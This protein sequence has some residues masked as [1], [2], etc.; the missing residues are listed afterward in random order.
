MSIRGGVDLFVDLPTKQFSGSANAAVCALTYAC[1]TV[2]VIVSTKGLGACLDVGL[3]GVNAG[4]LWG[5]GP[6][7][8]VG[9]CDLSDYEVPVPA[10]R[11]GTRQ[12]TTGS[13]EVA[14]AAPVASVRVAGDGA[15]PTVALIGPDGQRIVPS[16]DPNAPGATAIALKDPASS[17]TY[18]A[19]HAPAA[20][21]WRVEAE[22]GSVAVTGLQQALPLPPP[23]V[24]GTLG[25]KARARTLR[26]TATRGNG[27]ETTFVERDARGMSRVIGSA[28]QD[29][30]TLKFGTGTG[31]AGERTVLAVTTRNGIPRMET[32]LG[33][34]LAPPPQRPGRPR[35]LR[36]KRRG[37]G[38]TIRWGKAAR[39]AGYV[40]TARL[41]DGRTP[42]TVTA[43]RTARIP[44]V[45]RRVRAR[46]TVV[47]RDRTGRSGP[48][49]RRRVRRR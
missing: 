1:A 42:V 30:G 3:F 45:G 27:L 17:E 8:S 23:K 31:P 33:S 9:S 22:P 36:V 14:P 47:A 41:S 10:G 35:K 19:V 15:P 28:T 6:Q 11:P 2:M 24:T 12:A 26:Y 34:Y 13:F 16:E 5:V 39:A 29:A 40:V 20:G 7:A 4:Y 43:K 38:L 32:A 18:V 48:A 37:G 21:T 25:G 44:R 49:A 46:V